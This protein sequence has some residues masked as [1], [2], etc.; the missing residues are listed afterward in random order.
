MQELAARGQHAGRPK[1]AAILSKVESCRGLD[2][3]V[4][5]TSLPHCPD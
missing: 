1:V 3:L 4:N 5:N 2:V